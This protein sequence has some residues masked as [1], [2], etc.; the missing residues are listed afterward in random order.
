MARLAGGGEG[1]GH[2]IGVGGALVILLVAGVAGGGCSGEL[3]VNVAAGAGH[4]DVRAGQR[5]GRRVVV[6]AGR[7]PGRGAVAH[8]A[9][10]R[11]PRRR[12]IRVVRILEILQV[13][14]NACRAQIRKLSAHVARL[15]L[16]CGVRAS[17]GEAAER[18]VEF[19]IGPRNRA[20]ANGAISG[21]P[22]GH[23]IG[24]GRLLKIRHVARGAGRG[25]GRVTAVDVAL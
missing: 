16:Q 11:E 17:K 1:R 14:G 20:V 24:V 5:E 15:A 7:S 13:A 3:I 6:E 4:G 10:L 21:E 19:R 2:V 25:H 23:V 22:S 9:G 18:M 12:V 8:L